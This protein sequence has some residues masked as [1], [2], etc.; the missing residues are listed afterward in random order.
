M[1][2]GRNAEL[3]ALKSALDRAEAGK[4][5]AL[6]LTGDP[7]VGKSRLASEISS[8]ATAQGL[9][10]YCGRATRSSSVVP[11]RPITDALLNA[12]RAGRLHLAAGDRAAGDR[13]G[14]DRATGNRAAGDRPPGDLP[15]GHWPY[16]SVLASL[17]PEMPLPWHRQYDVNPLTVAEALLRMLAPGDTAGSLLVLEDLHSADPETLA[18]VDYMAD[19]LVSRP[20]LVVATVRDDHPSAG[21]DLVRSTEARRAA[22]SLHVPRLSQSEVEDMAR[23]CLNGHPSAAA[24]AAPLLAGCAGLPFAVEEILAAAI[25]SGELEFGGSGWRVNNAVSTAMPDSIVGSVRNRLAALGPHAAEVITAAAVLGRQFDWTLLPRICGADER[26]VIAALSRARET[27]LIEP[28]DPGKPTEPGRPAEPGKPTEPGEQRP[29]WLRFRHNLTREAIVSGLLPP[30]L[31]DASAAAAAVVETAH[32]GLPG[33]WCEVAAD[34]RSS[35]NQHARAARLLLRAG[36]RALLQGALGRATDV[37]S[38]ARAELHQARAADKPLAADIE[39]ARVKALSWTGDVARLG[40][41]AQEAVD[42]L[43][44]AGAAPGRQ[45]QL[46]LTAARA[47]SEADPVAAAGHLAA[48]RGIADRLG[49]DVESACTDA[50]AARC[51]LDVGE[52]D[53]AEDLA[54]RAL[55]RAEAAGLDG[56]AADVAFDALEV[57]GRRERVRDV[58]AARKAFERAAEIAGGD[59]FAVRRISAVRELGTIDVLERGDTRRLAEASKLARQAGAIA[60]GSAIDL[61]LANIWCLGPDLDRAMSAARRAERSARL[62]KSRQVEALAIARQ[63]L[64]YGIRA[65][66]KAARAAARRAESVV[67]G[68]PDVLAVTWGQARAV[69]SLFVDDVPRARLE[70]SAGV[71]YLEPAPRQSPR[72][73]WAIYAL[74]QAVSGGQGRPALDRA[75]GAGAAIAWS[76][77][78]LAYAEAVLAGREGEARRATELAEQGAELLRSYAPWWNH[79]VRRLVVDDATRDGWGSPAPWMRDATREFDASG[80]HRLAAACRRVLR[81]SGEPAPRAGRG[82]A[83]VPAQMRRLGV[84]SREMDVFLLAV[85]GLT[86]ADIASK[87]F[88]SPKTVETHIAN[89]VAKTGRKGRRDLVASAANSLAR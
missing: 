31:V 53:C 23:A 59:R 83:Q 74:L 71:G 34:L 80:H 39:E 87:L 67:P 76:R 18:T 85:Q 22:E 32:P 27:Q 7:G 12:A 29:G 9:S 57:L 68:S 36:R 33:V 61:R 77:A 8:L 70:S 40:P 79:L 2:I 42:M 88:I 6:F 10:V 58:A 20:V 37:L 50:V 19:N 62:I 21:L 3:R 11:F 24:S 35:A 15:P 54:R 46:L 14:R 26:D 13:A 89:L 78:W 55:A 73:A 72:R 56:W 38:A 60:T 48:A 43:N 51:A 49:H 84:T 17:L 5:G 64:I 44:A 1:L 28:T 86:N 47:E 63:A 66:H 75:R 25:A 4:G 65:D 82:Q 16:R 52:P 69:A 81:R 41:V 30:D 45:A